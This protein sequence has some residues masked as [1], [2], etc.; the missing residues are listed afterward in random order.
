MQRRQIGVAWSRGVASGLLPMGFWFKSECGGSLWQDLDA[1]KAVWVTEFPLTYTIL[2]RVG[3]KRPQRCIQLKHRG[4]IAIKL[5]TDRSEWSHKWSC[6]PLTRMGPSD[7]QCDATS[8][9]WFSWITLRRT[10]CI[11]RNNLHM[12]NDLHGQDA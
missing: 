2:R 6:D 7:S 11:V 3:C 1:E 9:K 5:A 4:R 12:Q 8:Q 10:I